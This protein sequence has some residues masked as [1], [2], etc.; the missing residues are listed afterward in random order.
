MKN[1]PI[2][3]IGTLSQQQE[4]DLQISRFAA[5]INRHHKDLHSAHKHSFYH[6]VLFTKGGGMQTIDFQN[7]AVKP[8]QIYFMIPGQVHSWD[9]EGEVDGYIINF[10]A[11]FFQSFLLKATYLED[12]PF[13]SGNVHD[14]VIDIPVLLQ[15]KIIDL[16]EELIKEN[17]QV[18][19]MGIDLVKAIMLQLFIHIARLN[20]SVD[21]NIAPSYNY[22]LLRNFQKLIEKNYIQLKLPKE[23]AELLYIT[24]NHLNALCNDVLDMPAGEVIRNRVILEAK[25]MLINRDMTVQEIANYLNFADNSYFTKF[26]KKQEGLTPDEFRKKTNK[27]HGHTN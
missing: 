7:F 19:P 21:T 26:F 4:H 13:F 5:Y 15:T 14:A 3:D 24:P 23:Y 17:E 9:F 10:S 18:K 1:I 6:L 16:F 2:Y 8:F 11:A 12:L 20:E 22:T 25:R 27:H